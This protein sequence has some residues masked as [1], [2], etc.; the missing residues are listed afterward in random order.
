MVGD[1]PLYVYYCKYSGKHALTTDCNLATAPR[2]RT[3]HALVLDTQAFLVKLYTTDGGAKLLRRKS[4]EVERQ[5]RYNVGKLPVAY[6]TEPD[7]RYLYILDNALTTYTAGE[8]DGKPP[9]PPCILK[10]GADKTQVALEVDDRGKQR[11]ILR[12]TADF[13]RVQV[14]S[15]INSSHNHEE[16]LE[17]LRGAL[18]VRL[19]QLSLQRGEDQRHKILIVEGLDPEKVF[20]KLQ[21]SVD[22]NPRRLGRS[23]KHVINTSIVPMEVPEPSKQQQQQ[24]PAKQEQQQQAAAK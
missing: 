15:A 19:G 4:G 9:V 12:V 1:K 3:D 22:K 6:R 13:V 2:R 17:L 10:I 20:A 21:E 7:G 24:E 8:G 23:S 18:G 5:I 14:K 16:L 11:L